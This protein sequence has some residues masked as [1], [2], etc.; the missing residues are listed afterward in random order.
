MHATE[1]KTKRNNEISMLSKYYGTMPSVLYYKYLRI[2][3]K[4]LIIFSIYPIELYCINLNFEIVI[5]FFSFFSVCV[6]YALP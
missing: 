1:L 5:N 2:Y 6:H 3:D 4:N